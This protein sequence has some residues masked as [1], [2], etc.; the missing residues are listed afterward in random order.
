M[1]EPLI[2][3]LAPM[4]NDNQPMDP[5]TL[6]WTPAW[7]NYLGQLDALFRT[8]SEKTLLTEDDVDEVLAANRV[9]ASDLA[10]DF[11]VVILQRARLETTNSGSTGSGFAGG[12]IPTITDGVEAFSQSFTPKRADSRIRIKGL[13]P[14]FATTLGT[15]YA[16][17]CISGITN[18]VGYSFYQIRASDQVT[19]EVD[20]DIASW[21]ADAR[22]VSIRV[23]PTTG[24]TLYYNTTSGVQPFGGNQKMILEIEEYMATPIPAA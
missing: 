2:S 11:G 13:V 3:T 20:A 24:A 6:Q 7:Q 23:A 14:F 18:A 1:V 17:S 19:A 5:K 4:P 16:F 9:K 22:S 12:G 8:L 15:C 21:G 10:D